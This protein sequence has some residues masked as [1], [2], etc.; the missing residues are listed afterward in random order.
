MLS[1]ENHS[2]S[3]LDL[4]SVCKFISSGNKSNHCGVDGGDGGT[5]MSVQGRGED[6]VHSPEENQRCQ[7]EGGA[8][9]GGIRQ[10]HS[11]CQP[12]GESVKGWAVVYEKH[13]GVAPQVF[14]MGQCCVKSSVNG[15]LS[16][17]VYTI[18]KLMWIKILSS[19]SPWCVAGWVFQ[20]VSWL[21]ML[22]QQ[23]CRQFEPGFLWDRDY[24]SW[25]QA[26]WDG[27]LCQ[28]KTEDL[29]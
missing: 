18:C 6:L 24:G 1:S 3:F 27:G 25:H 26:R 13:A 28:R 9:R 17:S 10:G 16:G 7:G 23:V 15:I 5:V 2:P 8:D 4:L 20:N 22:V 11:T 19:G 14:Q 12:G 21:M 29:G